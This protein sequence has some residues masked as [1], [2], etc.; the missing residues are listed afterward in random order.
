M[1]HL[2]PIGNSF[3][4]RIPKAIISQLGF[5]VNT[6]LVFKVTGQGLLISPARHARE[7]WAEAFK[8]KQKGQKRQLLMGEKIVNQFDEEE[9]EW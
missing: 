9:W 1:T 2:V 7:G 5:K 8:E 4:V 6:D 3:G